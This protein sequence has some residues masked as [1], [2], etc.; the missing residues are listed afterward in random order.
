VVIGP[1][2][3]LVSHV[4]VAGHTSIGARAVIYPFAS[5]G[6][7]PQ[8]TGYRGEPTRLVIG[9]DCNIR[10]G[11]T[12]NLGTAQGGGVTSVGDHGFYM[13]NSHVGH[14]CHVG[15]NVIFAN[16]AT[17]GGHC[18]IGSNVFIGGLS[19]VHQHSRVG[20]Q[21]MISGVTGVRSDVIP[22]GLA[23]GSIGRL[24]GLN[25]VG[26]R[27][28]K[29]SKESIG[30]VRQAYGKLFFGDGVFADR[31]DEVERDYG[32]EPAVASI[33]AF[34]RADAARPLCRPGEHHED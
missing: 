3:R 16:N 4:S 9:T 13:A 30:A 25:I 26:M 1:G 5:L 15:D 18:S 12:M 6:T 33:V 31:V 10:E 28:R 7:P 22:Y 20:E 27:R 19:A 32:A 34:I 11:V 17:L 24:G 29:M 14:D 21:A 8:S 23:I 2:C